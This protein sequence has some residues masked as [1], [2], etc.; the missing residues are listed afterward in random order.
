M[1]MIALALAALTTVAACSSDGHLTNITDTSGGGLPDNVAASVQISPSPI[2]VFFGK[3]VQLN[4][5]VR[6]AAGSVLSGKS[7]AW[8]S[9]NTA[10]VDISSGGVV[11]GGGMGSTNVRA[12]VEEV[13]A[14]APVSVNPMPVATVVLAPQSPSIV[15]GSTV[16][17]TATLRDADGA[18]LTGR[19]VAWTSSNTA[20]ATVSNTG[21]VTGVAAGTSSIQ[22][23]SEGISASTTVTVTTVPAPVAS[24]SVSLASSSISVGQTTQATATLRDASNNVL[25]GRT[26]TW[27]SSNTAVATVSGTG[28][29]TAV[30]TG[31]ASITA[32]SEGVSGSATATVVVPVA[33]V[34]VALNASSLNPSQTT[35]ATA[36]LRDAAG[37]VLTGRTVTWSSSNTAIATVNSSSGLVTA[38]SPG[39][40]QIR[41]SSGGVTGSATLTVNAPPVASV[42]VALTSPISV[43]QVTQASVTLRDAANNVLTGRTVTWASSNTAV[44]TVSSTGAVTGIAA[45]TTNITA[46]SEGVTGSAPLTVQ[47]V[48]SGGVPLIFTSD[49]TTGLGNSAS[50]VTD[51]N[52]T[53][54]WNDMNPDRDQLYVISSA[55]LGFPAN[56]PNVLRVR[57]MGINSADVRSIRQWQ[58][59]P[60]GGSLYVRFYFRFDVPNSYGNIGY[61]G[62]H[63][64]EAEP[65]SCPF[66]WEHRLGSN[67]NGTMTWSFMLGPDYN[68]TLNKGQVYRLEYAF[69]NRTANDTYTADIRVY[70]AAGTLVADARNFLHLYTTNSLASEA[71]AVPISPACLQSL[72][73]GSNGPSGWE[74]IGVNTADS[75]LYLGGV[76]VSYAG[77]PGPYVPGEHP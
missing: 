4:A 47:T 42:S 76:A 75:W 52:K 71:P 49:W 9:D 59:P 23:T 35:Q 2:S 15:I 31:T 38:V 63:P 36:T 26:I 6:N 58:T 43:G 1:R 33:S 69:K 65:G 27:A 56:M 7:I 61:Q 44:A 32:T 22:A 45:G 57:Y 54:H 77:W 3:T 62:N 53:P 68:V 20:V 10:I 12:T 70:D 21:V 29:V 17:L 25:T 5:V 13:S 30:S 11:H 37:N 41:A 19:T 28:V 55:G 72:T 39:T 64:I 14:S 34:S 60:V 24:V 8:T 46:T 67:S 51:A 48:Q 40:A 16:Q 50:A 73:M 66:E 74:T 18:V